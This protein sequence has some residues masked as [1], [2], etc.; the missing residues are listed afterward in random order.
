MTTRS[1][2]SDLVKDPTKGLGS[3]FLTGI[4]FIDNTLGGRNPVRAAPKRF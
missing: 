4:P 2:Q 1:E 3:S